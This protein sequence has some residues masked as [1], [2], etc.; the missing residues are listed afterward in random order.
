LLK[1][2][3]YSVVR[4]FILSSENW[5]TDYHNSILA[6]LPSLKER[7]NDNEE[8]LKH[9]A[10]HE[11]EIEMFRKYSDYYGYVVYEF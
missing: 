9:I 1:K 11:V 3:G 4:S 8:K 7:Y 6:K 2:L 5:W 10:K